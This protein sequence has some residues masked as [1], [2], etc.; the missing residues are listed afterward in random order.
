[1]TFVFQCVGRVADFTFP[2][3]KRKAARM[4]RLQ[5]SCHDVRV[6]WFEYRVRLSLSLFLAPPWI[7]CRFIDCQF[8]LKRHC[9]YINMGRLSRYAQ[10]RILLLRSQQAKVGEIVQKLSEEGISTTRQTVSRFLRVSS[11]GTKTRLNTAGEKQSGKRSKLKQEQLD[12]INK[13]I[14]KDDKLNAR[15]NVFGKEQSR[16]DF[17]VY[18]FRYHYLLSQYKLSQFC[19][20]TSATTL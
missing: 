12:F 9:F 1:M 14:E 4:L 17:H 15:G 11:D 2:P 6:T 20:N 13:E 5:C 19:D 10:D 8:F 16:F 18:K 7:I 3:E